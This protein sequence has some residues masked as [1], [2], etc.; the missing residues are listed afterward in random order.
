MFYS[1]ILKSYPSCDRGLNVLLNQAGD[2]RTRC[3]HLKKMKVLHSWSHSYIW[4]AFQDFRCRRLVLL[5]G[6]WFYLQLVQSPESVSIR[7]IL[8]I[9]EFFWSDCGASP[10]L[11]CQSCV[12]IYF[13]RL[14][15][16]KLYLCLLHRLGTCL[17]FQV[18]GGTRRQ[19]IRI[20]HVALHPLKH[21]A[22]LPRKIK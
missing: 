5:Q 19:I 18:Q 3:W 4:P 10:N 12:V 14:H 1:E 8:V 17:I 21:T 9:S 22:S 11:C 15:Q 7:T 20:F 13:T 6:M 2:C 16:W